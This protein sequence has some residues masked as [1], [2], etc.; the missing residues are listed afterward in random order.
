LNLSAQEGI[1]LRRAA[2]LRLLAPLGHVALQGRVDGEAD[3]RAPQRDRP[4]YLAT[5]LDVI[6]I[7][8]LGLGLALVLISTFVLI[9]ALI[10]FGRQGRLVI[11]AAPFRGHGAGDRSTHSSCAAVAYSL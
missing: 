1:P 8:A 2:L 6:P 4:I 11:G 5:C 3:C 10:L 9:L 7:H